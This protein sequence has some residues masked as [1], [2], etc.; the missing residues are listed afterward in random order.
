MSTQQSQINTL[1]EAE[2][3]AAKIVHEARQYRV[4]KLKDARTEA[5]KEIEEYKKAKESEFQAFNASYTGNTSTTQAAVDKE[6]EVKLQEISDAYDKHKDVVIKHLLERVALAAMCCIQVRS[7]LIGCIL[8]AIMSPHRQIYVTQWVP[9]T[10]LTT[11]TFPNNMKARII[12][13]EEI[14][15]I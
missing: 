5:Q 4:Q 7:L 12:N 10:C 1:L 11:R 13:K 8:L 15:M 6:T 2:K 3:K 9:A 14:T